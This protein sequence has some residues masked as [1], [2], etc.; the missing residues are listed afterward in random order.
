MQ[1]STNQ[2][3]NSHEILPKEAVTHGAP[4]SNYKSIVLLA[5]TP[6]HG[7]QAA[8]QFVAPIKQL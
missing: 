6:I 1:E 5:E 4:R 8:K 7:G 3:Q 2:F